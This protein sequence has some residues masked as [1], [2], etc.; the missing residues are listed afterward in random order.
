MDGVANAESVPLV[1]AAQTGSAAMNVCYTQIAALTMAI[2]PNAAPSFLDIAIFAQPYGNGF[3][4]LPGI[5]SARLLDLAVDVSAGTAFADA[6]A[7]DGGVPFADYDYGAL[8]YGQFLDARYK[9]YTNLVFAFNVSFTAAGATPSARVAGLLS[10]RASVTATAFAPLLR[11]PKA[12]RVNGLDAFAARTG[13]TTTPNLTW[14]A[15]ALGTATSYSIEIVKVE[16]IGGATVLTPVADAYVY[17]RL[18]TNDVVPRSGRRDRERRNVLCRRHRKRGAVGSHRPRGRLRHAVGHCGCRHQHL[19]AL[20][21]NAALRASRPGEK[22]GHHQG[23]PG[24]TRS[25]RFAAAFG[26]TPSRRASSGV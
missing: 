13:V 15:P 2:N 9:E 1:A 25:A 11:P 23:D 21:P 10:S 7:S 24:T 19:R 20:T 17:A 18:C 12:P 6:G 22:R 26:G 3:P 5:G 8:A 16:N 14:T 4:Y